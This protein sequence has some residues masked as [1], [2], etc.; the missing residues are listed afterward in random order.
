MQNVVNTG[1]YSAEGNVGH[2]FPYQALGTVPFYRLYS[3][4]LTDHFYTKEA[5]ERDWAPRDRDWVLRDLEYTSE[6]IAGYVYPDGVCGG[7]PFH[8]LLHPAPQ[9]DHHYTTA[10]WEVTYAESGGYV[11]EKIAAYILP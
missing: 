5:S 3:A 2:I 10:N 8:R 1:R 4:A 11:Y 6:G 7:I 9:T